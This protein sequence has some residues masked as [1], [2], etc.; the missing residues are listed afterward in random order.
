MESVPNRT[1]SGLE[2]FWSGISQGPEGSSERL[3]GP[4]VIA[5]EGDM[6]PSERRNVSEKLVGNDFAAR[7]QFGDSA[8]EIDGVLV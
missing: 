5:V 3:G 4:D 2:K 8:A 6:L 7:T 1:L